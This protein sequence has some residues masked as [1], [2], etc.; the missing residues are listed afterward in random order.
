MERGPLYLLHISP[1]Q[2]WNCL[3]LDSVESEQPLRILKRC[4]LGSLSSLET[5][6][7]SI[8]IPQTLENFPATRTTICVS[9]CLAQS[10]L[11]FFL[12]WLSSLSSQPCSFTL[13]LPYAN[14]PLK[15]AAV[16][17]RVYCLPALALWAVAFVAVFSQVV[18]L[19][20]RLT[21]TPST[22]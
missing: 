10:L 14:H 7:A 20:Q 11:H 18:P 9:C 4:F 3:V 19:F 13:L 12:V 8:I 6:S 22:P 5:C 16:M 17:E 21:E 15:D 1:K 2:H